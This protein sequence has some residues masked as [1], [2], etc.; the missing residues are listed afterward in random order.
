MSG[1]PTTGPTTSTTPL[2]KVKQSR[3]PIPS[4]PPQALAIGSMISV[5]LGAALS[6]RLFSLLDPSAVVFLRLAFGA[7]I[8]LLVW[9]PRRAT[10][11]AQGSAL[12][13]RRSTRYGSIALFGLALAAMTFF[14]YQ[15][16]AR[17][18]LGVAVTLEFIGP[19]GVAVSGSRRW[20]DLLWVALA[21]G[22]I[23]LLSPWN[24]LS[25]SAQGRLDPL[26]VVFALLAAVFWAAYIL[27]SA[28]VGQAF[29]GGAG[30]ALALAVAGLLLAPVG[31]VT[32]GA[33]L[34][35][36]EILALGLGVALLSS[37]LPFSL[38]LVALRTL[39]TRIFGILMSL[40]PAVA[41]L[42][43]FLT[44]HE[45]LSLIPLI[46]MA[47]V[48]LA[49]LGASRFRADRPAKSKGDMIE[50]LDQP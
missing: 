43:G 50:F 47:L 11:A 22:G 42:I 18:P 12:E 34:L 3:W 35:S 49:S 14:Y 27:L 21:A 16:I 37:A 8:L 30:L 24:P 40:E 1:A 23:V 41:T 25:V 29:S 7:V 44:L 26:G 39:P 2:T 46:A 31:I 9:R 28:R 5:Q 38:E 10:L 6:K 48:T 45:E 4:I 15:A 19:L 32:G 36:P 33:R 13:M 20:L 17:L